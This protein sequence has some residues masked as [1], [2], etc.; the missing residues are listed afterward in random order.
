[1]TVLGIDTSNQ[2][3]LLCLAENNQ[4]TASY[5][6][7]NQKNHSTTLMPGIDF[8][9]SSNGKKPKDLSKIIVAQGP[10]SYTGLR[11]GVTTAKT[12]AWTLKIDL[13]SVS[14]L[15]LIAA[16]QD[17]WD[18]LIVPLIN[19]R[20]ENIYSAAYKWV[21]EELITVIPEKHISFKEWAEE[22]KVTTERVLF[23]GL[24]VPVFHELINSYECD[25]FY[26]HKNETDNVPHGEA[27][28][29]LGNQAKLVD[30]I[31]GFNPN[32]LKKV[33]AEEKWLETHQ[34]LEDSHYVKRV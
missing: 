14:T 8:L 23:V 18:G 34:A 31:E 10:G 22:L 17:K 7:T 11:I 19:A 12:L 28:L 5:V 13:Y 29:R 6:T 1:M 24:D 20:R 4:L 32:Y 26:Y 3:M 33:E 21:D 27:F 25:A 30:D 9:M 2:S 16:G 15:A